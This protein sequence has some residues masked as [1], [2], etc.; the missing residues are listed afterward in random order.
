MMEQPREL[1][2][3][4][5]PQIY[6][7]RLGSWWHCSCRARSGDVYYETAAMAGYAWADHL[8]KVTREE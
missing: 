7:S 5:E 4:H 6:S 1:T 2:E 8:A 3:R